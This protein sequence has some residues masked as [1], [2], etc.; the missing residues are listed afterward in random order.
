MT[1]VN[2]LFGN[3]KKPDT[4][5]LTNDSYLETLVG[6]DKRYKSQEELAKAAMEKDLHIRRLETENAQY[7]DNLD[8]T[9]TVEEL[10]ERQTQMFN[11]SRTE[12]K[13][14]VPSNQN[15]GE[16]QETVTSNNLNP[17]DISRLVMSEI[18]KREQ[19]S[20]E[21]SNL[22]QVKST[23]QETYGDEVG[24]VWEKAKSVNGFTEEQ[25]Q[26]LAKSSPTAIVNLVNASS[27]KQTTVTP[28]NL[29]G[30]TIDSS[31]VAVSNV[32]TKPAGAKTY[33]EWAEI[34]RAQTGRSLD[35][36]QTKQRFADAAALGSAFYD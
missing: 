36:A 15:P 35:A 32:G 12:A 8:K 6:E 34:K 21:S 24:Q 27:P 26:S 29:F 31:K 22:N 30:K 1:D 13:N 10:L 4:I 19:T 11:E 20:R 5:Q 14:D 7:R 2:N 23:L 16:E 9:K 3:D 33:K 18:E 17:E 25:M 28:N